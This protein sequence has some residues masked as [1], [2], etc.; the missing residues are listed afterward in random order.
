M[1]QPE[2]FVEPGMEDYVCLLLKALYRLKLLEI[3]ATSAE[4]EWAD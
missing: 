4:K 2:G 1:E 3:I